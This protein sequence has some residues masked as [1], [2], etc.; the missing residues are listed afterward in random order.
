MCVWCVVSIELSALHTVCDIT[1]S[2]VSLARSRR[3]RLKCD[4]HRLVLVDQAR[5]PAELMARQPHTADAYDRRAEL[6]AV[7]V[8][9]GRATAANVEQQA[10]VGRPKIRM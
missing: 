8:D 2:P 7:L 5:G 3:Q 9:G 4:V 10:E 1:R 6:G